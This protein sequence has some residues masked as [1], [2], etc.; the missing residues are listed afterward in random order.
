MNI[1]PFIKEERN[2]VKRF[3]TLIDIFYDRHVILR[4]SLSA[5]IENLYPEGPFHAEFERTLSRLHEMED[6]DY[7]HRSNQLKH[8]L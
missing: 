1:T 6:K 2:R 8:A 5:S 4:L 7:I 3:I